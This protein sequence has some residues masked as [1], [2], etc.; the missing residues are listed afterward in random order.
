MQVPFDTARRFSEALA[1]L[2]AAGST[3]VL[4]E[5]VAQTINTLFSA[6]PPEQRKNWLRA[7]QALPTPPLPLL[8]E[9]LRGHLLLELLWAH[10]V[11]CHRQLHAGK[12]VA[13]QSNIALPSPP[14]TARERE[15]LACIA[16]GQT[17]ATIGQTLGIAPKTVSKHIEHILEKLGV[18]TRTA[19]VAAYSPL[20]AWK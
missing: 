18:E 13:P 8:P 7:L 14:L 17:D 20:G 5:V 2:H 19:A 10:K 4:D 6:H 16:L 9:I 11:Q 1:R 3:E 15:V 12:P